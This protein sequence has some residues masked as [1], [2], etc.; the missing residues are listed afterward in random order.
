MSQ[1]EQRPDEFPRW[2][3]MDVVSP[4]TGINNVVSPP[5]SKRNVGWN[6]YEPIARQFVNWLHRKAFE[7]IVYLDSRI[8]DG[9]KTTDGLGVELFPIHNAILTLHAVDK[10]NPA[11]FIHAVGYRDTGAPVLTVIASNTLSLDTP[12]VDGTVPILGASPDDII[13]NGQSNIINV[14]I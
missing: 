3:S 2:A 14:N 4:V 12:T 9:N 8:N 6:L 10:T 7:W 5:Q 11:N 1:F 13:V